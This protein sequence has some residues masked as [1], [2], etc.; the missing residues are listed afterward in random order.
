MQCTFFSLSH[1]VS[2]FFK[3]TA[4]GQL[5]KMI[6][7]DF[8]FVV[9]SLL[10]GMM[11]RSD[12]R[13]EIMTDIDIGIIILIRN[14]IEIAFRRTLRNAPSKRR[15]ATTWSRRRGSFFAQTKD[16]AP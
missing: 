9:E 11:S 4:K 5:E 6:D 3:G 8:R 16:G 15:M 2:E 12:W 7:K 14:S 10:S 1:R 13:V